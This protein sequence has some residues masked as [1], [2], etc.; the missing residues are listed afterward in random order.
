MPERPDRLLL[1]SVPKS[2]THLTSRLAEGLGFSLVWRLY[3]EVEVLEAERRGQTTPDSI[4]YGRCLIVHRLSAGR[5][6]PDFDRQWSSGSVQVLFNIR[7]PRDVLV[8]SLDYLL[9]QRE[10]ALPFP[11]LHVLMDIVQRL[12]GR[13]RQMDFLLDDV[14][15]SMLGPLHPI[16]V[17]RDM[18][19]L[20]LHP[21]CVTV[22][23]EDLAGARGG[24]SAERQERAV[25]SVLAAF[26]LD[27]DA[28]RLAARLYDP[29]AAMFNVGRIGRW[30]EELSAA[31][32]RT[33]ERNYGDVLAAYGYA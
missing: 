33:F 26:H 24:G 2:G 10:A 12:D 15:L 6:T 14:S 19:Y 13:E 9:H 30:R 17:F 25:A 16:T 4:P 5:I 31:Q 23:Y 28:R 18:R 1:V 20:A 3:H 11:G 29:G 27:G 32:L 8:S 22:R 7:D 21:R